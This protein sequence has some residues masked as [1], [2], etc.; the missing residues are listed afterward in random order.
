MLLFGSRARLR[1][2]RRARLRRDRRD[3]TGADDPLFVAGLAMILAGL[4]FKVSAAPFHMWT[5][6]VYQ[7]AP[8]PVTAFMAAATK[9]AA[10]VAHAPHPRDGVPRAGRD[11]DGRRRRARRASRSRSGNLAAIAQRDVKR[12]LAYSSISHAG[13]LLI[14]IA[15]DST[16]A[17]RRSSTT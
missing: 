11:L 17:A 13:F 3:A 7:G 2:D 9:I 15:A 14:A 5:P 1:R 12:L 8:T 16:A 10:L 4:A 6:D